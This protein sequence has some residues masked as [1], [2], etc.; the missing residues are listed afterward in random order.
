[1]DELRSL[2]RDYLTVRRA[3][4]YK[5]EGSEHHLFQFCRY[6][7]ETGQGSVTTENIVAWA[8]LPGGTADWH[9]KRIADIRTFT[10]W[11]HAFDPGIEVPPREILPG[12]PHRAVPFIYSDAQVQALMKQA[13][14]LPNPM[15]AATYRTLIGLLAC[16][17]MRVG[18]AISLDR[19]DLN[20]GVLHVVNGKRGGSRL[21]PLHPS[22]VEELE[23]YARTRDRL[24]GAV[25]TD[26]FFVSTR[27]TRLIYQC[28]HVAFQQFAAQAGI[29]RRSSECRPRIH[30]LRHTFAVRTMLDAY[31]DGRI[32]ADVLPIL[33]TYLG[34]G[35]PKGTYW[36][37]DA[38]P[39]L[40]TEALARVGPLEPEATQ[41]PS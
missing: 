24:L 13:S 14:C 8:V 19:V 11:A 20:S 40:M 35:G 12:R 28:F 29:T 6:L 37:L 25:A 10:R 1:M 38:D 41:V 27:R 34:H 9:S 22:V 3:L 2:V 36:Y 31:R 30:D 4:G 17:G 7:E 16:T 32:P 26:A 15:I 23:D 5:L 33:A 39:Q 18:E 21:L